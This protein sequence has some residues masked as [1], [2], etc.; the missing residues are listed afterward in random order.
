MEKCEGV[1]RRF[2]C[3]ASRRSIFPHSQSSIKA[4]SFSAMGASVV[5]GAGAVGFCL[6]TRVL[7]AQN[8]FSRL[9][10]QMWIMRDYLAGRSS[11]AVTTQRK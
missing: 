7:K 2:G 4:Y 8:S 3:P 1:L 11:Y 9:S 6:S 10:R 5:A